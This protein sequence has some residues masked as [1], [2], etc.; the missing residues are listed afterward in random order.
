MAY[1]FHI[2]T[3]EVGF[4]RTGGG[5]GGAVGILLE[6]T[7]WKGRRVGEGTAQNRRIHRSGFLS[8]GR[9]GEGGGLGRGLRSEEAELS[10]FFLPFSTAVDG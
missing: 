4:V 7:V 8:D 2:C 1:L 3:W 5:A 10:V 9:V 6:C